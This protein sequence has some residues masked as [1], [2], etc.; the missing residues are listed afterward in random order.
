MVNI[1]KNDGNGNFMLTDPASIGIRHTAPDGITTADIDNDGDLDLLL[2]GSS[3]RAYLYFNDSKGIFT[4]ARSFSQ[5]TGY[6]GGFA[7][8]DNDGDLDLYF[9]G[10]TKIFLNVGT[11]RFMPG[12]AV[13]VDGVNDPRSVAFADLDN[14]GDMDFAFGA[15]RVTRNYII[16]NDLCNGGNWLKVRLVTANGQAGAYGAKTYIYPADGVG[17]APLA[18]RESQSNCGY[19]GQDDP[20]LHFGLGHRSYV[21]IVVLFLDGIKVV[22]HRVTA[23]QTILVKGK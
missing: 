21:D 2:A 20:V 12:P 15:K 7:D 10:D 4:L 6:M 19:L 8:L 13:P 23:N 22:R 16:R 17:G 3:G 5:T 14:D 11:G 1:L 9:A 18:M